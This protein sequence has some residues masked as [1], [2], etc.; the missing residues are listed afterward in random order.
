[1]PLDYRRFERGATTYPTLSES[2]SISIQS[3]A[4]TVPAG[5]GSVL[6]TVTPEVTV[7]FLLATALRWLGIVISV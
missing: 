1:M 7:L 4:R 2:S 3:E 6:P 5:P